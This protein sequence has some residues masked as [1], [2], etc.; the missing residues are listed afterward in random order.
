MKILITGSNGLLGQKIVLHCLK[1]H[2]DFVATSKGANRFSKCP[3]TAYQSLDITIEKEVEDIV[4]K[5]Q[6]T[7]VINTAAVTNVDFCE[8]NQTLCETVN[9]LALS[10]LLKVCTQYQIHLTQLSTDFVFDGKDGPY[11]EEDKV[12]PLSVYAKSKVAAENLLL[13]AAYK[14]WAILRTIIVFG[15]GENLSRSNIVLWAKAA[16]KKGDPL[17][18]VDDQFR[19]PTWASDLA[20][21]CVRVAELNAKGIYHI[22]GPETFSIF[23]LVKRIALFYHLNFDQVQPVKSAALNQSAKR[24]P[25]TGFN[26]DKAR[27]ELNYNPKTFEESLSCLL[28]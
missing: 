7:H 26:I 8:T 4:K 20:W 6:P 15:E 21:A 23:D 11:A 5:H 18:I 12:N 13:S 25:K 24:P 3:N 19:A 2:I 17:T 28:I 27:N 9:V 10:F 1:H 14:N 16:L 22:S